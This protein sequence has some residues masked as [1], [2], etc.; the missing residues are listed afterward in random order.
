MGLGP[1]LLVLAMLLFG[2]AAF[3][4]HVAIEPWRTRFIAAGLF[5]WT[6]SLLIS[7][8]LRL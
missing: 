3:L 8:G 1:I 6:L 4:W 2:L 7:G 5:S